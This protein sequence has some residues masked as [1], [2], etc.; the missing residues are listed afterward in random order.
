MRKW[1]QSNNDHTLRAFAAA[2]LILQ[3]LRAGA[4][5]DPAEL[6]PRYIR[7]SEAEIAQQKA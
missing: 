3:Q 2:P 1:S 5:G 6:L 7:P 4:K